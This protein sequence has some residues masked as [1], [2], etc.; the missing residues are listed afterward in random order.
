MKILFYFIIAVI[1]IVC[2]YILFLSLKSKKPIK[3]LFINAFFGVLVLFLINFTSKY[4][5]VNLP[6]NQYTLIGGSVLGIPSSIGF[7]ILNF[8]M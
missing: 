3:F 6:I 5:G 1:S 8:L 4:T 2:I 7:L